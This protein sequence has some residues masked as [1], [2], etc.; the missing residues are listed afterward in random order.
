MT[1]PVED[2]PCAWPVDMQCFADLGDL[3]EERAALV[4]SAVDTATMI[5]WALTGRQFGVCP[6]IFPVAP[7]GCRPVCVP[8][9]WNG[10][11]YNTP[12]GDGVCRTVDL[13][14]PVYWIDR[15]VDVDGKDLAAS[16]LGTGGVRVFG[17]VASRGFTV[18]YRRGLPVP[19]GAGRMVG[20]L[21]SQRYL[22]CLGDKKCELPTNTTSVS[23]QG[24][25]VQMAD[26]AEVIGQGMV[27]LPD[28]DAWVRAV[29]PHRLAE[30]PEVIG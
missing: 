3:T 21:A 14:G 2:Q 8:V 10:K 12:Q 28:V 23:R 19:S 17:G 4:R 22:Q 16:I 9:L 7:D 27:G 13:P 18:E 24:V 6:T 30:W 25:T 20:R 1:T 5:L 26:P 15:V 11:W 29:N